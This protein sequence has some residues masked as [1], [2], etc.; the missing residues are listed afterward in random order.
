MRNNIIGLI[1]VVLTVFIVSS[2]YSTRDNV[3]VYSQEKDVIERFNEYK[4]TVYIGI[5]GPYYDKKKAK[6]VALY[7]CAK[8]MLLEQQIG[9]IY[10]YDNYIRASE[11]LAYEH[12]DDEAFAFFDDTRIE[13]CISEL[14]IIESFYD[15]DY[16]WV[17]FADN[18]KKKS[19]ISIDYANDPTTKWLSNIP[20]DNNKNYAIA[21]VIPCRFI[22]DT[23]EAATFEVAGILLLNQNRTIVENISNV[24]TENISTEQYIRQINKGV[25]RGF[26]VL[27]FCYSPG[28]EV[29]YI[30]ACSDK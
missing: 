11:N 19:S 9:Y 12:N 27:A 30:L 4:G 18:G 2:C 21:S 5:S 26:Q 29:C 8:M 23:L 7:N 14:K 13:Q 22:N 10:I 6:K 24:K 25:L 20:K 15:N 16:G 1:I 3:S 28:S 17:V